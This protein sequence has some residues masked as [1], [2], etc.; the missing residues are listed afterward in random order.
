VHCCR[1]SASPLL[2]G[3]TVE[4]GVAVFR[5]SP[6]S[7]RNDVASRANLPPDWVGRIREALDEDRF[8]LYSQPSFLSRRPGQRGAPDSYGG[9]H[10]EIIEPVISWAWPRNTA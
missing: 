9:P 10:G 5:T 1:V 3:T 7:D 8:V 6:T 2:S 4:G